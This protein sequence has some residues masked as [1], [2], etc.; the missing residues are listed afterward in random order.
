MIRRMWAGLL[1]KYLLNFKD[2][3]SLRVSG[4]ILLDSFNG[5]DGLMEQI[6][7]ISDFLWSYQL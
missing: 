5:N 4:K 2:V 6:P 7:G 3:F 1:G